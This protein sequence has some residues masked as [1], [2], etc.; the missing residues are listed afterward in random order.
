LKNVGGSR[1]ARRAASAWSAHSRMGSAHDGGRCAR[2][3]FRPG[4]RQLDVQDAQSDSRI[5]SPASSEA[6]TVREGEGHPMARERRRRTRRKSVIR[7]V[8][9]YVSGRASDDEWLAHG[10]RADSA[11]CASDTVYESPLVAGPRNV[12][13]T[14]MAAQAEGRTSPSQRLHPRECCPSHGESA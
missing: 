5:T 13:Y 11:T 7:R 3:Q 10:Q 9:T 12:V 1:L 2:W 6:G 8:E 14:D 4:G